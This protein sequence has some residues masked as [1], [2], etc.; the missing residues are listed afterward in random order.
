[1]FEAAPGLRLFKTL[2]PESELLELVRTA[3]LA[4]M[5]EEHASV[6]CP[7]CGVR[8]GPELKHALNL[9]GRWLRDGERNGS[10]IT[11]PVAS[12]WLGGVAAAYQPWHSLILRYL[13]GL[14]EYVMTGAEETLRATVQ[15][16]EG[17]VREHPWTS[18]GLGAA[19][20]MLIGVLMGRR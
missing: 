9:S 12:F 14:R 5:A 3:D 20:G 17:Y 16:T 4:A 10:P 7:H 15:Q 18:I 6:W 19:V 8:L 1:M 13:Q 11:S 2:P